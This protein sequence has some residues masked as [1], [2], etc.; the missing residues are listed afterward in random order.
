[1]NKN[2]INGEACHEVKGART[3]PEPRRQ[4]RRDGCPGIAFRLADLK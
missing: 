1:M 2:A 3:T 4:I